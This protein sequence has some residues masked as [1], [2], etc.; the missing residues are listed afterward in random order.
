MKR[1]LSVLLVIILFSAVLNISVWADED[2][3]GYSTFYNLVFVNDE[4]ID[5]MLRGGVS[6]IKLE[7]FLDDIDDQ[8]EMFQEKIYMSDMDVYFIYL[9]LQTLQKEE[10][11]DA[12]LSFDLMYQE[13]MVY[14]LN[15]RKCPESLR[16]LMMTAFG[17]KVIIGIPG[18]LEP[19]GDDPD[20]GAET[21]PVTVI[22]PAKTIPFGDIKETDW[23]SK[24]VTSLYEEGIVTGKPDGLFHPLLYIKKEEAIKMT[25]LTVFPNADYTY[26]SGDQWYSPYI[27]VAKKYSLLNGIID[28]DGFKASEPISRQDMAAICFRALRSADFRLE[29]VNSA[30]DFYDISQFKYYAVEPIR[31]LQQGG[32]IKGVGNNLFAPDGFLSRAEAAEIINNIINA[33]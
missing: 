15:E 7:A 8:I 24:S 18:V 23:Y 2:E 17:D 3:E 16:N 9:F 1:K 5:R 30:T 25:V 26:E 14:M 6:S 28:Y 27:R 20:P 33:G 11:I 22:P 32:I 13:E 10:H 12:L 21:A 4:F 19:E 31:E 29:P